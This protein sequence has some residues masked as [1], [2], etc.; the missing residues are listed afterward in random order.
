SLLSFNA[1]AS[2]P[3]I[4]AQTLTF[5]LDPG[6]PTGAAITSAGNFTF[7]PTAAQAPGTYSV[8]VRVTDSGLP[9]ALSD[10]KTFQIIVNAKP[11][12]SG[13]S[14]S[15]QQGSSAANQT[16]ASVNDAEDPKAS[17]AVTVNGGPT[18]T[19]NG[20]TVNNIAVDASGNV[21]AN[22]IA[23]CTATTATFTLKVT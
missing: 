8:T 5:T 2:D 9:P 4:P 10:T 23:S 14:I 12:I 11:T 3:D 7:T 19:G 22:V 1:T 17:L 15:Q 21:T 20:V 13:A 6:Y 18:A 16:I